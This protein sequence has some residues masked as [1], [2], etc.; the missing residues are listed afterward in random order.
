MAACLAFVFASL[1]E[2]AVVNA[3]ARK[4]VSNE[5]IWI[6]VADTESAKLRQVNIDCDNAKQCHYIFLLNIYVADMFKRL[7]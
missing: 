3:F 7:V 6:P 2:F 1:L 5:K 4:V